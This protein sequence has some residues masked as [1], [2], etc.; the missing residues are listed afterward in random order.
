MVNNYGRPRQRQSH[1]N[2]SLTVLDFSIPPSRLSRFKVNSGEYKLM[3]LAPVASLAIVMSF[4]TIVDLKADGSYKLEMPYFNYC[5]G[6]TMTNGKFDRLFGQPPR[7]EDDFHTQKHM[8]I[9]ASAQVVLEEAVLA[10]RHLLA[11]LMIPLP[12]TA[13]ICGPGRGDRNL[14]GQQ[15]LKIRVVSKRP[16]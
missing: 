3:G 1:R 10:L 7:S 14:F 8:D 2:H 12:R 15:G 16:Q 11:E 6:L 4:E 5:T 9:A 13:S